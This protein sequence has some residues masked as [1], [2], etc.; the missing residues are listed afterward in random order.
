MNHWVFIWESKMPRELGHLRIMI[1]SR[2]LFDLQDAHQIFEHQGLQSYQDYLRTKDPAQA[3]DFDPVIGGRKLRAGPLMSFA[4][5]LLRLNKDVKNGLVEVIFLC[6]DMADTADIV[7]A[8]LDAHGLSDIGIRMSSCGQNIEAADIETV[9]LLLSMNEV[10]VQYAVDHGIAASQIYLPPNSELMRKSWGRDERRPLRLWV[11][12]DAVAFGSSS[13]RL[14]R[15]R[16]LDLYRE[17]EHAHFQKS[18]EAGPFSKL[19]AKLSQLNAQFAPQEA[20]FRLSLLTARG[21]KAANR[22]HRIC[23]DHGFIF[24][25]RMICL[26]GSPKHLTLS[27][28]RPDIFFDDQRVHLDQSAAFTMTGL[29]P[30]PTESEMAKYLRQKELDAKKDRDQPANDTGPSSV[31][32]FLPHRPR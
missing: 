26:D 5:A 7:F 13:E 15:E 12:G 1:S 22:V 25:D 28:Y 32:P 20:P 23:Q 30:Y 2:C 9:D 17:F 31:V 27:R 21:G 6:K 24:N 8:N 4:K 10:D 11:D 18:I 19:L 16:G 3:H 14:Y 29:V